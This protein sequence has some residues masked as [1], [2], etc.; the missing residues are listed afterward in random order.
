MPVVLGGLMALGVAGFAAAV[1]FDRTRAFYPMTLIV[2]ASYDVLFA[3]MQGAG[4]ALL[5][6]LLFLSAFTGAAVVGFKKNLWIVVVAL[7]A[8]A[9]L[10]VVHESLVSNPGTPPWWPAFCMAYDVVAAA[11]LVL[12]ILPAPRSH[13]ARELDAAAAEQKAARLPA[14]F[15]RL[16]RAHVLGQPSTLEHVRVH[17]RMLCWG[18]RQRDLREGIGQVLRMLGA[19]IGTPFGLVP[20]GNTGGARVN[21]FQPMDVPADLAAI[22][23]AVPPRSARAWVTE[24]LRA[25]ATFGKRVWS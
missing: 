13:V 10:D 9:A 4:D 1:G 3:V 23:A 7:I 16:E 6:A 2:I 12:L 11:C 22:L 25:G 19:A 20:V 8:H 5:A 21:P 18:V 24:A 14:A 15:A 17:W